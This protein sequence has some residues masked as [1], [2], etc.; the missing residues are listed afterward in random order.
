MIGLIT[1][2]QN[3]NYG[4][5]L[6]GFAMQRIIRQLGFESQIIKYEYLPEKCL[7]NLNKGKLSKIKNFICK[8]V[9]DRIISKMICQKR[10]YIFSDFKIKYLVYTSN[11][12]NRFNASNIESDVNATKYICGSDQ[13]WHPGIFDP[14]WFLN[15]CS[16]SKRIAFSVSGLFGVPNEKQDE[17]RKLIKGIPKISVRESTSA[18][19]IESLIGKRPQVTIDPTLVIEKDEWSDIVDSKDTRSAYLKNYILCYFLG[20]SRKYVNDVK[21]FAKEVGMKVLI[22]ITKKNDIIKGFKKMYSVNPW[23]FIKLFM[24][25]SYIFTDSFHGV[26]F[27]INFNK[28]FFVF[29]RFNSTVEE[30][31]NSRVIDLLRIF[32][33]EERNISRNPLPLADIDYDMVNEVLFHKRCKAKEYIKEALFGSVK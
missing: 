28:Q 15:F 14:N 24:G 18:D 19:I 27:A 30:K 5:V 10:N 23:D 26:A 20:E 33:L 16:K 29:N 12:Y 22:I 13:I 11:T 1:M 6:Q 31:Q 25:A 21:K 8:D 32:H 7:D 9:K 17:Y 2:W 4:T 3:N